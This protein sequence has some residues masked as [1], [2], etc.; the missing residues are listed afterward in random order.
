MRLM[1]SEYD[2]M[3]EDMLN[4]PSTIYK[5]QKSK[6]GGAGCAWEKWEGR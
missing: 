3:V 6:K 4:E 1:N 2:I 5:M